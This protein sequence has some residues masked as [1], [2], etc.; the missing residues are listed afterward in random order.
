M[1]E[2]GGVSCH[3]GEA[4]AVGG[5]V[6]RPAL[7]QAPQKPSNEA[8]VGGV[9]ARGVARCVGGPRPS[10]RWRRRYVGVGRAP[11]PDAADP[12][13]RDAGRAV[14][15]SALATRQGVY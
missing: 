8:R 6:L 14:P 7:P 2:D 15:A 1:A 4:G 13:W 9:L 11:P 3:D 5:Q 12:R 10:L